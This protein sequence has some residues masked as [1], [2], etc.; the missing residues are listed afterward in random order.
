[1]GKRGR[2]KRENPLTEEELAQRRVRYNANRQAR[3]KLAASQLREERREWLEIG[4]I[5]RKMNREAGISQE[6]IWELLGGLVIRKKIKKWCSEDF[7][8]R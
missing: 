2:K 7:K 4:W 3:R 5:V 8:P 1:M 6:R